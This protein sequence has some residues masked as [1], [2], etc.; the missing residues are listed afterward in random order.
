MTC[1]FAGEVF[2]YAHKLAAQLPEA[3]AKKLHP[4][5]DKL[6]DPD[7]CWDEFLKP[8][9]KDKSIAAGNDDD[10]GGDSEVEV[11]MAKISELKDQFNKA[12][13]M[14]L[15][16]LARVM[17]FKFLSDC[18]DLAGASGGLTKALQIAEDM[19]IEGHSDVV[20]TALV[21]EI[22][23]ITQMFDGHAKTISAI[24]GCSAPAPALL[25]QL[26]GDPEAAADEG[27]HQRQWKNVQS[28]RKRFV[29]LSVPKSWDQNGLQTAF[30]S[31][32][33]VFSFS[34][35]L[36]ASHRM[37][38][39]SADLFDQEVEQPWQAAVKPNAAEWSE[40][41][42]FAGSMSGPCDFVFVFDGRSREIRRLS[43]SGQQIRQVNMSNECMLAFLKGIADKHGLQSLC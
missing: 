12:T 6:V 38:V 7:Q 5:L 33:R 19:A 2:D 17:S 18:K 31:A 36:N 21:K 30:R 34:G 26:A 29:T 14:L 39:A 43:A 3:E 20:V 41:L 4:V 28:E 9:E 11:P 23:V 25:S 35:N 42:A 27:E 13:G 10:D 32:S 16:F 22:R 37:I 40:V 24:P 8:E 1:S 15:D